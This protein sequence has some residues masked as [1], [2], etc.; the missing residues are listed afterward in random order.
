MQV[1][2]PKNS[3]PGAT[4][5]VKTPD[6]QWMQVTVPL[7]AKPK[8]KLVMAY[9]PVS[10]SSSSSSAAA[11]ISSSGS[12]GSKRSA[13]SGAGGTGGA[14]GSSGNTAA[15]KRKASSDEFLE[16]QRRAYEALQDRYMQKEKSNVVVEVPP[17]AKAG[18][19]VQVRVRGG[20][21][22]QFPVP[23]GLDSSQRFVSMEYDFHVKPIAAA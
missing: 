4:F 20:Q 3:K 13:V 16:E 15:D 1:T 2:V 14:A 18:D 19:L 9:E 12:A 6:K 5:N 8:Q 10:C 17:S 22:L 11:G 21:L 23:D 7:G